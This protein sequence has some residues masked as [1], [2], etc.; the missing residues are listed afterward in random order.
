M[1]ILLAVEGCHV[2]YGLTVVNIPSDV[3]KL[4]VENVVVEGG[5]PPPWYVAQLPFQLQNCLGSKVGLTSGTSQSH[6][7]LL[8]VTISNYSVESVGVQAGDIASTNRITLTCTVQS[9]FVNHPE[10]NTT[11]VLS[12]WTDFPAGQNLADVEESLLR[13]LTGQLCDE[14]AWKVINEW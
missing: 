14:I 13:K 2:K 10:R 3:R 11:R 8:H 4:Y 6:D 9:V 5:S 12:V 1:G 7:I